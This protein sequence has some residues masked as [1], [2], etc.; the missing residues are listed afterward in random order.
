M[1]AFFMTFASILS[2]PKNGWLGVKR[3]PFIGRLVLK[4]LAFVLP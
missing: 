2:H 4:T 1:L 3:Y